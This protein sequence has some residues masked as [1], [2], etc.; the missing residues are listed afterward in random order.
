MPNIGVNV[1][2]IV[3]GKPR[4]YAKNESLNALDIEDHLS[5]Q[6]C[7]SEFPK[8]NFGHPLALNLLAWIDSQLESGQSKEEWKAQVEANKILGIQGS[9]VPI[10]GICVRVGA[11]R[12][13]SQAITLKLKKDLPVS[14]IESILAKH[15]DWVKVIPDDRDATM[16]ELTPAKVTGTLSIPVGRIRKLNMGPEYI[17]AFTVGDQLLWGAAEPLRRMLRI[18]LEQN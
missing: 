18:V 5:K 1:E 8:D 9:E 3:N 4:E 6:L 14:E 12:C 15:N 16:R 7:R 17:S 11:M 2:R 10:D 13:H